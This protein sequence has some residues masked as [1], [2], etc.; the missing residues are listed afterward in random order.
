MEYTLYVPQ[1]LN[2][3]TDVSAEFF[4]ALEERL[5][6]IAG[7]FTRMRGVGAYRMTDGSVK[8]EPVYVYMLLASARERERIRRVAEYVKLMLAQ[9]SVLVTSRTVDSEFV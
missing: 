8:R 6:S 2:N 9:E 1:R 4:R 5:V 3:D 7:G